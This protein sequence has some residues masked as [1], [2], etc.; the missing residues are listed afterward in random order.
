MV[1][2]SLENLRFD[3]FSFVP[4]SPRKPGLLVQLRM[5]YMFTFQRS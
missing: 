4:I 3:K 2:A 5:T 1:L